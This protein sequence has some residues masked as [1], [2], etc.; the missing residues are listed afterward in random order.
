[1]TDCGDMQLSQT[2]ISVSSLN[3]ECC[4]PKALFADRIMLDFQWLGCSPR[5]A[6]LG[7]VPEMGIADFT[8]AAAFAARV[9]KELGADVGPDDI[10]V[11]T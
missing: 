5:R 6:C 4:P 2:V 9:P 10:F 7:G 11:E 1:M 3:S 8:A